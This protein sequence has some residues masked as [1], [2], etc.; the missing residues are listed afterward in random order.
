VIFSRAAL[1]ECANVAGAVFVALLAILLTTTLIRLL[2]Q[3]AGGKLASEAVLALLGFGAINYLPIILSLTLFISILLTLSR[4]YRDGEMIIW[5]TAGQPLTAWV[6]PVMRF[7]APMVV[8]IAVLSLFLSPWALSK[9]AEYRQAMSAREDMAQ[10]KAGSFRESGRGDRVFFVEGFDPASGSVRNIFVSSVQH[11]RLGVMVASEGFQETQA[12]GDRFAVLL[13]GRRYEGTAGSPEYRVMEFERYA[14]RIET[15]EARAVEKSPKSAPLSELLANPG[16]N[17]RAELLWRL[18][19]PLQAL[20]LSLLAI[21]LSFVNPR[22]SR[23]NN[24]LL[25]TLTFLVYGNLINVSQAWVAQGKLAFSY[26]VWGVHV[27][28][29]AMLILLFYRRIAVYPWFRARA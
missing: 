4:S 15:R 29:F 9:S 6:G 12:N 8:L 22:A 17:Y 5:F 10:I 7:A 18:A 25:A 21:P 27:L 19:L 2:G 20:N 26:G 16:D 1:R 13:N 23:G 28:M 3:A 14:I 24:L 11:G